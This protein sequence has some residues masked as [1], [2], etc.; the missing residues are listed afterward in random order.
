MNEPITNDLNIGAMVLAAGFG[1]RLR[2]LTEERPKP[3]VE[4]FGR[5]LIAHNLSHLAR[6]GVSEVVINTHHLPEALPRQLGSQFE[7]MQLTFLEEKEILGT[8]G[9]L[10]NAR[11][12]LEKFDLIFLLNADAFIDVSLTHVLTRQQSTEACSALLLKNVANAKDFGCIGTDEDD[13][14]VSFVDRIPVVK[15]PVQ[16]RMFCGVHLFQKK[17]L[18]YL[19]GSGE[20]FCVNKETYPKA[21]MAQEKIIGVDQPGCFQDVGTPERLLQ[22]HWDVLSGITQLKHFDPMAHLHPQNE[23]CFVHATASL[24]SG[25]LQGSQVLVDEQVQV[26]PGAILNDQVVLGPG[27]RVGKGVILDRVVVQ[28]HSEIPPGS[29][30]SNGIVYPGGFIPA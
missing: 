27:V 3:L 13:F 25:S 19:D 15:K 17:F 11:A 5:P 29:Q 23:S 16:E 7:G 24:A 21:L 10:K 20:V 12:F 30:L 26:E 22:L 6:A 2:P 1:T 4:V 28:S 9:G 14:V 8:G 18:K